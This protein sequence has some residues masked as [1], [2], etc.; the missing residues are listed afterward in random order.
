[1]KLMIKLVMKLMLMLMLM[2][3]KNLNPVHSRQQRPY[4]SP[5]VDAKSPLPAREQDEAKTSPSRHLHS[6]PRAMQQFL[7]SSGIPHQEMHLQSLLAAVGLSL[8]VVECAR[9]LHAC[10]LSKV[11][12]RTD[13]VAL[14]Q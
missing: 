8:P 2:M 13:I 4:I 9:A 12:S 6:A 10:Y 3:M 5:Y 1:M 11:V 7:F 14:P